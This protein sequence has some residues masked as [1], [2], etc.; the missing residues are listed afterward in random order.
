MTAQCSYP[1]LREAVVLSVADPKSLGRVQ[2]KVLPELQKIADEDCPWVFPIGAGAQG[3][4]FAVKEWADG[5][6]SDGGKQ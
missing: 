4:D 5:F 1:I 2:L 3:K 6:D